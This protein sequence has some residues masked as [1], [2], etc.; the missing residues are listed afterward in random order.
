MADLNEIEIL[1]S[2]RKEI[3]LVLG[4]AL[5]VFFSIYFI[6]APN[7]FLNIFIRSK[8][9]IFIVGIV[10]SI[11]FG[12]CGFYL[13]IKI[14]DKSPGLILTKNGLIDNSNAF[15]IGFIPWEDVMNIQRMHTYNQRFI[16]IAVKDPQKY[17]DRQ[18]SN[19]KKKLMKLNLKLYGSVIGIN[20]NL[21]KCDFERLYT[22]IQDE[23]S[24]FARKNNTTY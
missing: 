13:F 22:L 6:I 16:S 11:F 23:Y 8:T 4:C 2:K 14:F 10:G 3:L 20:S 21:L 18:R 19:F 24:E 12:C 15:K 9:I 5:F 1:Q 7:K 17:I